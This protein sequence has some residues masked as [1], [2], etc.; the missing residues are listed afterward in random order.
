MKNKLQ[1][2]LIAALLFFIPHLISAQVPNL[3]TAADFVLFTTDGPVDMT[4]IN[5]LTG[6]VG[7]NNGTSTN[8]ENINGQLHDALLAGLRSIGA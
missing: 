8:F 7:T 5:H 3:G 6:N 4:S 1:L 2:L